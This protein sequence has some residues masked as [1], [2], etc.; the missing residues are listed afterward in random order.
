MHIKY[1]NFMIS[2]SVWCLGPTYA[3]ILATP[4]DGRKDGRL[5]WVRGPT[6]TAKGTCVGDP[7]TL[8]AHMSRCHIGGG[9]D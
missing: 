1:L 6:Q 7:Q 4:L 9:K 2:F 8:S 3:Q 5:P